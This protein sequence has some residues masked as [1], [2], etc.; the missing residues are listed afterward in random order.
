MYRQL[1]RGSL[2]WEAKIHL[3]HLRWSALFWGVT[4]GNLFVLMCYSQG[5]PFGQQVYSAPRLEY[6]MDFRQTYMSFAH[7]HSFRAIHF[8]LPQ[9]QREQHHVGGLFLP[10][11][12]NPCLHLQVLLHC[13]VMTTMTWKQMIIHHYFHNAWILTL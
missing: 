8:G 7:C 2:T 5:V 11:C 10:Q 1:H 6:M 13:M 4:Y 9:E 3:L 12:R